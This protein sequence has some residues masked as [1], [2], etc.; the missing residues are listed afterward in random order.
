MGEWGDV[1]SSGVLVPDCSTLP[2]SL[3]II[4]SHSFINKTSTLKC[5][6]HMLE[7]VLEQE[8]WEYIIPSSLCLR[9]N[10]Y[11]VMRA[12]ILYGMQEPSILSGMQD[13]SILSGMREPSIFSGIQDT[14]LSAAGVKLVGK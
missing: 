5:A 11:L 8:Q 4:L 2:L 9:K 6:Y 14:S 7:S 3:C 10:W 1:I 13:T 12:S